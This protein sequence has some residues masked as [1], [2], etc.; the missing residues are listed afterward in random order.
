[1]AHVHEMI[2][3]FPQG[4]ENPN[5]YYGEGIIRRTKQRIALA[6]A[7]YGDPNVGLS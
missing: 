1:M 3:R 6:R 7:L 5:W 4:Y 2:L